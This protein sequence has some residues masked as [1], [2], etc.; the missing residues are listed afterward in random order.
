MSHRRLLLFDPRVTPQS[1]NE[2]MLPGE[3]AVL[4]SSHT[5]GLSDSKGG[6]E[7]PSCTVFSTL[8]EAVDHART[9]ISRH[10]EL[11]C[12]VYDADGLGRPPLQEFRGEKYRGE[13]EL[14]A[15]FRRWCG[16]IL[17]VGGIALIGLDAITG[18]SLSWPAT[19]GARAFPVGLIL[20][21]T[22]A[23]IVW[24]ARRKAL[25][26]GKVG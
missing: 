18:F 17:F 9:E 8:Q 22:E 1:W 15:R 14:S 5:G 26:S 3:Y 6:S 10:P 23:V 25:R 24:E 4:Y 2:R 21:A 13:S 11:R 19:I 20:L 7:G 12:R 16:S